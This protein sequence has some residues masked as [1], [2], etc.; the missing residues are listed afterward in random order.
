MENLKIA[1]SKGHNVYYKR[2]NTYMFDTGAVSNGYIEAEIVDRTCDIFKDI[3]NLRDYKTLDVTPKDEKFDNVYKAHLERSKRVK[4][5][6]PNYYLDFHINAGGGSG[7]EAIVYSEKSKSV[8]LAKFIIDEIVKNTGLKNRGIKY[9]KKYYSINLQPHPSIILE[10][11]FIDSPNNSDMKKLTPYIYAKSVVDAIDR[12]IGKTNKSL[13]KVQI[14][15]YKSIDNAMITVNNL[16][17]LGYNPYI[18]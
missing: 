7:V 4:K 12:Y 9:C 5:Y 3:M 15:A 16:K 17:K 1:Y 11:G 6:N 8:E 18:K 14:G 2:K 13:Y 10:G